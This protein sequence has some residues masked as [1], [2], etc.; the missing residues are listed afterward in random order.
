MGLPLVVY[1]LPTRKQSHLNLWETVADTVPRM[2]QRWEVCGYVTVKT[3][4]GQIL[5][6]ARR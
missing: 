1:S 6:F 3:C 5:L 4:M 2:F